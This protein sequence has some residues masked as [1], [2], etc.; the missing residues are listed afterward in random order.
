MMLAT[1]SQIPL[2]C[3]CWFEDANGPE[4]TAALAVLLLGKADPNC[5]DPT[6]QNQS[7]LHYAAENEAAKAAAL[8][9]QSGARRSLSDRHGPGPRPTHICANLECETVLR[10][11][12]DSGANPFDQNL[13]GDTAFTNA[14]GPC[15]ALC[16]SRFGSL[17]TLEHVFLRCL[18]EIHQLCGP[19]SLRYACKQTYRMAPR[20]GQA[21]R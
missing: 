20:I 16:M 4:A 13:D 8:L 3:V 11:F 17:L 7:V 21:D 1:A 9:L 10:T 2:I 6:N 19:T 14:D 15:L 12:F 5:W 18:Y